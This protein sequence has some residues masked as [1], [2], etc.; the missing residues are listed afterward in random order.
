V[1]KKYVERQ[2][3]WIR[4]IRAVVSVT[5]EPTLVKKPS[6]L[7]RG[8]QAFPLALPIKLD[9]TCDIPA[10]DL[11]KAMSFAQMPGGWAAALLNAPVQLGTSD[12]K[13]LSSAL[14]ARASG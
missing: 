9:R 11:L 8:D 13:M 4:R 14:K 5:G 12:V 2:W 10:E 6:W 7:P 1:N 3:P